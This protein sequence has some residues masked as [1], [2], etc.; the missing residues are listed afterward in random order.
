MKIIGID[1]G[2]SGALVAIDTEL[3]LRDGITIHKLPETIGETWQLLAS[4]SDSVAYMERVAASQRQSQKSAIT[5]AR[6]AGWLQMGMVAAGISAEE[7]LPKTWQKALG[8][9]STPGNSQRPDAN[10]RAKKDHK[11]KLRQKA[12]QL[13]P[14]IKMTDWKAD[15][16]LIAWYGN[17]QQ[18]GVQTE[19]GCGE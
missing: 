4:Y 18:M 9:T 1:P 2:C 14:W 13:F 17:R 7:I 10:R 15:A 16:L 11:K 5:S 12:E 19:K 3:P 8:I 6:R